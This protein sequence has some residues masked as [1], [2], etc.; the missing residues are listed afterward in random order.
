[1]KILVGGFHQESNSFSS[2][3]S[4]REA[5]DITSGQ[6][7]LKQHGSMKNSQLAGIISALTEI[8]AEIIPASLY[9]ASSGGPVQK[10][11]VDEFLDDLFVT[12]DNYAPVD[13]IF[14]DLHGATDMVGSIDCCGYILETIR[15]HVGKDVV[16]AY[17]TDL[18]ANITDKMVKYTD[19][20]AGYHTYPHTDY[21][22][23][24]YRAAKQG[25]QILMGE[26]F[27]QARV[28]VPMIIPAEAY[29]TNEGVFAELIQY[30]KNL[31]T[32]GKIVDFSIYQMQPWLNLA[33]A[34][35]TVLVT[36][37]TKETAEHYAKELAHKLFDLRREMTI[38]LYSIEEVF[39]AARKNTTNMPVLLVD[40][41]DSPNAGSSA[42]SSFVLSHLLK[43]KDPIRS[44]LMVVDA[45]AV[46]HA[47]EIGV[48]NEGEFSL[49]GTL[50]PMFQKATKVHAYVRSLHDG[51]CPKT[52]VN[53]RVPDTGKTAVLQIG[54]IDIV[55]CSKEG[56]SS[57]P[58]SYRILGLEP[59]D[60]ELVLVKSATQYKVSYSNFTTLF[61]PTDTPGSSTA[62]LA[63]LP[64]TEL[65]RPFF[66]LDDLDDFDDS[67]TYI[68]CC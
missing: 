9:T 38:K 25:I 46:S 56:K 58:R 45:P 4:N 44:C 14:M 57:N 62:N 8:N 34:G 32:I 10:E 5:F 53:D 31:I 20:I 2:N 55:V 17:G 18:H 26:Q 19:A 42:D 37:A 67:V 7:L 47:F 51:C 66:P 64:F 68:H 27:Y 48:G 6:T 49:G 59:A 30:A 54:D 63:S 22:E 15:Q 21:Y 39:A 29:D 24:G 23:T 41:A 52:P 43:E 12:Y 33:D 28:R 16:I 1:M 35:G 50:E 13:G 40:S 60:Y 36:A 11:V 61:Y 3:Y 65:P